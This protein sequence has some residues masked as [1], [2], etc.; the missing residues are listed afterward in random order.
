MWRDMDRDIDRDWSPVLAPAS[1]VRRHGKTVVAAVAAVALSIS[2][3]ASIGAYQLSK[4]GTALTIQLSS[5]V[6][7]DAPIVNA[8]QEAFGSVQIAR[9]RRYIGWTV[10]MP[11]CCTSYP[12]PLSLV[13]HDGRRLVRIIGPLAPPVFQ[14]AFSA[15][16]RS[17]VYRQ[18]YPHGSSPLQFH[19]VRIADGL[20]LGTFRCFPDDPDHPARKPAKPPAWARAM[21]SECVEQ[22]GD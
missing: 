9:N 20:V 7:V 13:V 5:G 15:D 18:E 16:S 11:N 3:H 6:S 22:R 17:L 2:A 21:A 8:D 4:D 1:G 14:W 19:K 12:L 10:E